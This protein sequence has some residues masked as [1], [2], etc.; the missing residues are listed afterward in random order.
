M[1]VSGVTIQSS[2]T[3]SYNAIIGSS[4]AYTNSEN[5]HCVVPTSQLDIC[6][7]TSVQQGLGPIRS[8]NSDV[9][10][11]QILNTLGYIAMLFPGAYLKYKY[12]GQRSEAVDESI[13]ITQSNLKNCKN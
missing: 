7:M 12:D 4:Q 2:Q 5:I 6:K 3:G 9:E 8:Y 1:I 13:S 11:K 10:T